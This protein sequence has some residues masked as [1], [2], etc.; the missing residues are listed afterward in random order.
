MLNGL[1]KVT[2]AGILLMA[3]GCAQA[4]TPLSRAYAFLYRQM[5][6]YQQGDSLR[7]VR[8]YVPTDTF[9][10]A[11]VS[12]TYDDDV[13][14]L[15]LLRRGQ[16]EDVARARVLGDALVYAQAHDPYNDGRVRGAYHARR[17]T[18]HDG[19]PR[20]A[21]AASDTGNLAWTGIAFAQLYNATGK[22]DYLSAALALGG[23]IQRNTYDTR[24]AG[25]YTGGINADQQKI[26]YKS[27]EHNIDLYALFGML[28]QLTGEQSW[29]GDATH[30]LTFVQAMWNAKR[31]YFYIGTGNDGATINK[32]DPTPE[33]VQTWSFLSTGLAQYQSSM[34][35]A[36]ANL[37]A[38]K[39]RFDGLSF[40]AKDRSG[41]WFEGT[42]HAAMAFAARGMGDDA[43]TVAQLLADVEIG[44]ANAPNADGK[45]VVAA[46][47]DGLETG[48]GADKYY[49]SLHIGATAWYCLAKQAANPFR[50]FASRH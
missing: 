22:Q 43:Q 27:T 3:S 32:G 45:G 47:K 48:D 19:A 33:D 12:Y 38:I 39:G 25:G 11:D 37:S 28:A 13:M 14:L 5:D 31:G 49:A 24:G 23:F 42:A 20:I 18:G 26:E 30:A 9:S 17:F 4:A 8:S 41:V 1:A 40:E 21:G 36:L 29:S 34:D 46:S 2:L 44:Q 10:N 6:K 50:L 7:L 35:W 15:A 16:G